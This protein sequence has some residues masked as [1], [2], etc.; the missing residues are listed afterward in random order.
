MSER[1]HHL[2]LLADAAIANIEHNGESYWGLDGK[3]PFGWSGRSGIAASVLEIVGVAPAGPDGSY[4]DEQDDYGWELFGELADH[5]K[6]R[7]AE[8]REAKGKVK[9]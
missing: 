2:D 9:P 5:V 7:W 3:R 8:F 6:I 1:E 4:T